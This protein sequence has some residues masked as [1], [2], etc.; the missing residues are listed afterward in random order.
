MT[1]VQRATYSAT[2]RRK[3]VEI[4]PSVQH[5]TRWFG[6]LSD[7]RGEGMSGPAAIRYVDIA[8]WSSLTGR[9]PT[10]LEVRM[11]VLI[12]QTWRS[13]WYRYSELRGS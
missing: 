12:D 10:P 3:P 8:A 2:Q 1:P 7:A 13:E 11:L 6:E 5:I 9:E 4:P